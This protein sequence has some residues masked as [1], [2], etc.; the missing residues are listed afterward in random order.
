MCVEHYAWE[1]T[2]AECTQLEFPEKIEPRLQVVLAD[3][4][5][6]FYQRK[7][8]AKSINRCPFYISCSNY[9]QQAVR[10]HGL[11][12]GVCLFIDRH[13]FREN[14]A[15]GGHYE[16]RA[17]DK[18]QMKLDDSFFLYPDRFAVETRQKLQ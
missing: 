14:A 13:L 1:P 9:A 11:V 6:R 16:M 17:N 18:G 2:Y 8:G 5:I 3:R 7:I 15:G 10:K 4:L 12:A